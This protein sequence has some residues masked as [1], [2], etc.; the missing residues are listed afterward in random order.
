[1]PITRFDHLRVADLV[2]PTVRNLL[3]DLRSPAHRKLA[4]YFVLDHVLPQLRMIAALP[5]DVAQESA[6]AIEPHE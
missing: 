5:Q 2:V 4:Y 6:D 3:N 1:M